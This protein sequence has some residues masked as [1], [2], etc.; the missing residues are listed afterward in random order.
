MIRNMD[1]HAIV[2]GGSMA[3]LLAAR[4]LA[5]R[6]KRVTLIDLDTFP[7]V[8]HQR[9]GVPQ[10]VHTHALLCSGRRVIDRL[11]P[12]F[13]AECLA[14]GAVPG[15]V[16]ADGRWYFEGG[17]L[18]KC[19]SGLEGLLVSR[20]LLEG[21]VRSRVLKIANLD[22]IQN[23]V[24]DSLIFS[25]D[26]RA[27][28]G[29]RA[30][31]EA[32]SAGVVLDATGRGSHSPAWLEANGY[33]KPEEERVEVGIGY[34]TRLFRRS[35]DQ[36]NGDGAVVICP[37]PEGKRGGVMCAQEGLRWT[38]TLIAHFGNYAPSELDGFVEF[39]R[40]L[41]APDIYETIRNSEPIGEPQSARFPASLRRRYERLEKFPDGYFVFGDAICSFNPIY[42]QGMSVAA[43]QA[44]AL[45]AS[46][47]HGV[48][49]RDFFR[50]AAKVVDSPWSI[51]VGSDLRISETKGPR[52]K[53]VEFIN[54]YMA[55][56]HKAAHRDPAASV[57][58]LRVANLVAPP[59]SVMHPKVA[60]RVLMRNLG[61]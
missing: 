34:T 53:G 54:W 29:V 20:P 14:A 44:E 35:P 8:G 58:F 40:N 56:L 6:C 42:A 27:V 50:R 36:L 7:E 18:A 24:V 60:M 17:R 11:L 45:E 57:A 39:A 32:L 43:L 4:V 3:G 2:I 41:P 51:A 5:D 48:S 47:E 49:A 21:I 55:K 10:G 16:C 13:S 1:E 33:A 61:V 22:V 25:E 46:L 37:T 15:D 30:N 52:S 9:R 38:V 26:K 28:T 59:P 31:G 12:G 19:S 23:G